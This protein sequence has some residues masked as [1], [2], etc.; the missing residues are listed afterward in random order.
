M[1]SSL[2]LLTHHMRRIGSS[3]PEWPLCPR[4]SQPARM[5]LRIS[6]G[7]RVCRRCHDNF[8]RG[9]CSSCGLRRQL[10]NS[11][12]GKAI[13]RAC[14]KPPPTRECTVCQKSRKAG[15]NTSTGFVCAN[16]GPSTLCIC[17][18]CSS[19]SRPMA[20]M[21]GGFVCSTCYLKTKYHALPCPSCGEIRILSELGSQSGAVCAGCAGVP[22]RYGCQRCGKE[23]FHLGELC[24]RC[25]LSDFLD[26][27]IGSAGAGAFGDSLRAHFMARSDPRTAFRWLERTAFQSLFSEMAAGTLPIAHESLDAFPRGR[28]VDFI[29]ELLVEC[30]ALPSIDLE[31]HNFERWLSEFVLSVTTE[32]AQV[33]NRYSAWVLLRHLRR[34][35]QRH[36]VRKAQ[37][38]AA[39]TAVRQLADL[40]RWIDANDLSLA[41]LPQPALDAYITSRPRGTWLPSMV[42]WARLVYGTPAIAKNPARRAPTPKISEA[43]RLAIY[44]EVIED[45]RAP[46]QR[47]ACGIAIVFGVHLHK[48]A[49]ITPS[50]FRDN[51][52]DVEIFLR[53][54]KPTP[55][56]PDLAD[57]YRAHL[58][59]LP[60]E[61]MWLFP[62]RRFR[63][64]V[65]PATIGGWI[66]R[67]GIPA[68]QLRVAALF[69]LAGA[70]PSRLLSDSTGISRSAASIYVSASGSA[71]NEVSVLYDNPD[72]LIDFTLSL[73]DDAELGDS[74]SSRTFPNSD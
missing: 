58:A 27:L 74:N 43:Q 33:I 17:V 69:H 7:D 70:M 55:L 47:L 36:P 35:A 24:G 15:R 49:A 68:S 72:W 5:W 3:T 23:E 18:R 41:N 2:L 53:P 59:T 65:S 14:H 11:R 73:I 64:H 42:A 57:L 46:G 40:L 4:C 20:R 8:A 52:D 67:Y 37:A 1:P 12:E 44:R 71:W 34:V 13:C 39:R 66:R 9:T 21:L 22:A 54:R 63:R 38:R 32:Q 50:K 51:G 61:S 10:L 29:R 60:K 62:G 45:E 16:C 26:Q 19:V 6:D 56:P 25:R 28:S 48:V 31:L 30:G